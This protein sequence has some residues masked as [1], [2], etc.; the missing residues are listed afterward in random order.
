[1]PTLVMFNDHCASGMEGG[2]V[3]MMCTGREFCMTKRRPLEPGVFVH[4]GCN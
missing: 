1:M 4:M 2:G 3:F